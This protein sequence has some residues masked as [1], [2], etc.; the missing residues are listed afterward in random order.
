MTAF[1]QTQTGVFLPSDINDLGANGIADGQF[2]K[3]VSGAWAGAGEGD[4][5]SADAGNALAVGSDSKL[6]LAPP[7]FYNGFVQYPLYSN[8]FICSSGVNTVT[9][10]IPA[11][12]KLL[13]YLWQV[14]DK[15]LSSVA[16]VFNLIHGGVTY[17]LRNVSVTNQA[18]TPNNEIVVT[19]GDSLVLNSAAAGLYVVMRGVF[20][21]DI[22]PLKLIQFASITGGFAYDTVYTC[23]AGKVAYLHSSIPYGG[24]MAIVSSF[25]IINMAGANKI[26]RVYKVPSGDTPSANN[27]IAY[28]QANYSA[29]GSGL[30]TSMAVSPLFH[31]GDSLVFSGES[32]VNQMVIGEIS[33]VDA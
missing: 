7:L 17:N 27:Q 24:Q 15:D 12:Y 23:P 5:V 4:M 22:A 3:R 10:T 25:R 33:E 8:E 19:D 6:M 9:P 18:Q 28:I 32:G 11:G 16:L 21:P 20:V 14:S 2:A 13:I 29:G 26:Y 30:G 1:V 31:A